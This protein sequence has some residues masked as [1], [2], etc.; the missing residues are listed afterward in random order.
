MTK[1]NN[2]EVH[3]NTL[4]T[5]LQ[6]RVLELRAKGYTFEEIART[7]NMSRASAYTIYK[8]ALSNIEK[9]RNTLKL[10]ME[11]TSGVNIVI[12][13]KTSIND[14]VPIILREADIYGV[15]IKK[16]TSSILLHLFKK[17][18]ECFNLVEE[19]ISCNLVITIKPDGDIEVHRD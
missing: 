14:I 7:L 13:R 18:K 8:K 12:P 15:K 1:K 2:I 16:S 3:K 19:V 17:F 11:I 5:P 9:A 6:L 4:L 10:Y